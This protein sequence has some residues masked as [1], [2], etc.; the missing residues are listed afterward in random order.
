MSDFWTGFQNGFFA[1]PKGKYP[2]IDL[3]RSE[4][5]RIRGNRGWL[6][7]G[8]LIAL[9]GAPKTGGFVCGF[10]VLGSY[11]LNYW[12]FRFHLG[13]QGRKLIPWYA[14]GVFGTHFAN[15]KEKRAYLRYRAPQ[16]T[17]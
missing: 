7:L 13:R 15:T 14:G 8:M 5:G 1:R 9:L 3:C 12:C 11:F 17:G 10:A 2:R 16:S 6:V 4:M